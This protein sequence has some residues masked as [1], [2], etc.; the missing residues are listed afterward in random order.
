[1]T[2]RTGS[3]GVNTNP[4]AFEELATSLASL[5]C[6]MQS[7]DMGAP[8][9]EF[10]RL[11]RQALRS[12][13]SY[14]EVTEI[15]GE[16][17]TT[18][19]RR[20][21]R[22]AWLLMNIEALDVY[23]VHSLV[24]HQVGG[25]FLA[26]ILDQLRLAIDREPEVPTAELQRLGK[27]TLPL[28]VFGVKDDAIWL[29]QTLWKTERVDSAVSVTPR[30]PRLFRGG[31]F[32]EPVLEGDSLATL[33][34]AYDLLRKAFPP[35]DTHAFALVMHPSLPDFELYYL[36]L[37]KKLPKRIVLTE[38]R[39]K[40]SSID[41]EEKLQADHESLWTLAERFDNDL[42]RGLPPCRGGRTLSILASVGKRQL[43]SEKLL[44][45][46]ERQVSDM[47]K[48]DFSYDV[49]RDKVRHDLVDRLLGQGF[50]RKRGSEYYLTVKGMAR[51]Q[52]CLAKYTT[53]GTDDPMEVLQICGDHRDKIL[54]RYGCL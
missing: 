5:T 22:A 35:V 43:Q 19:D 29:V 26:P 25:K 4:L 21:G 45:W 6:F 47:L 46:K 15:T 27:K 31:V 23:G 39:I 28:D 14:S 52:Y 50:M 34:A 32:E 30:S 40:T 3:L 9:E 54:E 10:Q 24:W 18:G 37:G 12:P 33:H 38:G 7:G 51:Y 42:F 1:M 48:D 8:V 49:P 36:D 11:Y 20:A 17:L 2:Q 44:T 41:Y 53:K 13:A 16:G